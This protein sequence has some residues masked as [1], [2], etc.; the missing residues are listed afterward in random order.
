MLSKGE[1]GPE[2]PDT[3]NQRGLLNATQVHR[4]QADICNWPNMREAVTKCKVGVC[5]WQE[6]K[7]GI[8][9]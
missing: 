6:Q 5:P 9:T 3:I 7:V 4:T 8:G 1:R 2:A